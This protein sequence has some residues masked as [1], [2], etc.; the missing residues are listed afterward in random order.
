LF[1]SA[2]YDLGN[3]RVPGNRDGRFFSRFADSLSRSKNVTHRS[4]I[5]GLLIAS[6]LP[7][8]R[9]DDSTDSMDVEGTWKPLSAELAGKA[10]P[11]E[12]LKS[13]KLIIKGENYTA[14]VGEGKDE[15]TVK[16]DPTKSP[17][18]MDI[19]GTKGPNEG[20]TFL[21]IYELKGDDLKVCYDLSGESRPSEFATKPDTKLFLVSY[22]REKP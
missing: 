1:A 2:G 10:F 5:S 12:V 14:E 22:R 4:L 19:K 17:K 16:L 9:G 8:A 18:A 15:G 21:V 6:L 20:K 13:M 3:R 11:E 7:L